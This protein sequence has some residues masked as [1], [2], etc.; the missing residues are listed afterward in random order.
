MVEETTYKMSLLNNILWRI[1]P[2]CGVRSSN[3]S[4]DLS[5]LCPSLTS[6]IPGVT[7]EEDY[8]GAFLSDWNPERREV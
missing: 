3:R 4:Y 5:Y 8:A 6:G 7:V 1:I 2:D